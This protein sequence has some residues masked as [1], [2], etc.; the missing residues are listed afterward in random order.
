MPVL[1]CLV[2]VVDGDGVRH[3]VT[4]SASSLFEAAAAAVGAFRREAWAVAALT[5]NAVLRVEVQPPPVVHDV[6]LKAVE[7]WANGSA[8]TPSE[9]IA[10]RTIRGSLSRKLRILSAPA[11]R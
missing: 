1:R 5:A 7:R 9:Q 2:S 11:T 8:V 10:K 3:S 4:V 6:P